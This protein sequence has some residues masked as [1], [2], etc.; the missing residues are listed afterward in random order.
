M[1]PHQSMNYS[2]LEV[3]FISLKP[4]AP[5]VFNLTTKN[6][7]QGHAAALTDTISHVELHVQFFFLKQE[8]N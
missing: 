7:L 1:Y 3:C 4:Q 5:F 8:I 2:F 6:S